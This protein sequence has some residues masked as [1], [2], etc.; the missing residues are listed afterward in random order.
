[1]IHRTGHGGRLGAVTSIIFLTQ[2][3][4]PLQSTQVETGLR[5]RAPTPL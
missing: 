5:K 3:E 4:R 1:M 2:R